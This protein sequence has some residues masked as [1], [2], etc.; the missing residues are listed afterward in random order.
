MAEKKGSE[1]E[2]ERKNFKDSIKA[3]IIAKSNNHSAVI[4]QEAKRVKH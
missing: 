4:K 3:S 1:K 2:R